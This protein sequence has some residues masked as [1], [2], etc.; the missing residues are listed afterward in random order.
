MIYVTVPPPPP[1]PCNI[2]NTAL[3]NIHL[4]PHLLHVA[5]H[6]QFIISFN[7]NSLK[8]S[9]PCLA[10]D[11]FEPSKHG[12]W[13]WRGAVPMHWLWPVC[14]SGT[15]YHVSMWGKLS[16]CVEQYTVE[17]WH[18]FPRAHSVYISK[19]TVAH[20]NCFTHL[21]IVTQTLCYG[22]GECVYTHHVRE[23]AP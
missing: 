23:P 20:A 14:L 13:F 4:Q 6:D 17:V 11:S 12:E 2:L 16:V 15:L 7:I 3:L 9:F 8:S 19:T 18:H 21:C 5:A 22:Y 10:G 1:H